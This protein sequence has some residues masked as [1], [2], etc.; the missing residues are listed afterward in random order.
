MQKNG[1]RK[2]LLISALIAV[3]VFTP[4]SSASPAVGSDGNRLSNDSKKLLKIQPHL[5]QMK[6]YA[7]QWT[8]FMNWIPIS[9]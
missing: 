3:L 5:D 2:G 8:S 6:L 7:A 4:C 1:K 9:R